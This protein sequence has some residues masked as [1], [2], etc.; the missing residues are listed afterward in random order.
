MIKETEQEFF[1]FVIEDINNSD[2]KNTSVNID[3][4]KYKLFKNLSIE[5]A[6]QMANKYGIKA[7]LED[8]EYVFFNH[9]WSFR[10]L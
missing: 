8:D 5:Q 2:I 1:E 10:K 7:V 4:K 3:P 6:Y 9:I